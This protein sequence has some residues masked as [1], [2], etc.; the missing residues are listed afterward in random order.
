[1]MFR[2]CSGSFSR[3]YFHVLI[4]VESGPQNL[5]G[6]GGVGGSQRVKERSQTVS[7]STAFIGIPTVTE[8]TFGVSLIYADPFIPI[9]FRCRMYML[10]H[11][12]GPLRILVVTTSSAICGILLAG[13]RD[14]TGRNFR[15]SSFP[16]CLR[17]SFLCVWQTTVAFGIGILM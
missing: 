5:W 6:A 1:M 13:F 2:L 8:D 14:R 4:R 15:T 7:F 10:P 11:T 3:K 17:V 12:H 16:H 9:S